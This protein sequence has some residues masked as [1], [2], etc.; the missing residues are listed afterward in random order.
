VV[1][2][3]EL[4]LH[5][6]GPMVEF[7]MFFFGLDRGSET[8][9]L[10][11]D[12][13]AELPPEMN[14]VVGSLNAPPA[15][16]VPAEHQFQ[17]GWVL[18]LTGF[19]PAAEHAAATGRIRAAAPLWEMVTPMPYTQLQQHVDDGSTAWGVHCYEKATYVESL[20]DDVI[21]VLTEQLP[22]KTSPMSMMLIYLLGGAYSTVQEDA[23]AFGGGRS[24]R[25][26]LFLVGVTMTA[27]TLPAERD[28]V[29]SFWAGLQP[30]ALGI[31]SYV[32]GMSEHEEERLRDTYGAAKYQR[33]ARIKA[34][35]D[36]D[37]V[38]DS[39]LNI[40]PATGPA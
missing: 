35:Y 22:R 1:T 27:E 3:F 9:R 8:L 39:G 15:P 33:L 21:A 5:P 2:R 30:A 4:R 6:V 14:L 29:R 38:F 7:G 36:P 19:G 11:R 12:L 17:P 24:P 25:L 31:G 23:T 28:W 16:F 34:A 13:I 26:A 20:S 32:N 18:I 40:A 10:A 37:N